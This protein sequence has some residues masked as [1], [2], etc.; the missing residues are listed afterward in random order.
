MVKKSMREN[1]ISSYGKYNKIFEYKLS[2]YLGCR[3]ILSTINGTSALHLLMKTLNVDNNEEVLVQ[4]LTYV[5][6][7]NSI[8][9]CNSIPHFIDVDNNL[10]VNIDKLEDYLI[11][12]TFQKKNIFYNKIKKKK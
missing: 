8:L 4:S 5:S 2:N 1:E 12:N 9:Y 6:T 3:D 10:N 11:K 7:I